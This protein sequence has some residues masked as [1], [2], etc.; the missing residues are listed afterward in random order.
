[1]KLEGLRVVDLTQFLPGPYLTQVMADHGAEVLKIEPPSGEPVRNVGYRTKDGITTW[2]R[3]THRNKKS[4]VL[5]LKK[6]GDLESLFRLVEKADVFVEAFRPGVVVR[7]ILELFMPRFLH[8]VKQVQIQ[9]LLLM[10][11]QFRLC[12]AHFLLISEVTQH[13]PTQAC[14]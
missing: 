10:I 5:D 14:Q 6:T 12:L 4:I 7:L 11:S 8:L 13:R 2:F 3:N 1:M 9:P